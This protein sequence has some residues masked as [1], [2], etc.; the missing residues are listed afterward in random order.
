MAEINGFGLGAGR[1]SLDP[2]TVRTMRQICV[3]HGFE[4]CKSGRQIYPSSSF[5]KAEHISIL[6][7]EAPLRPYTR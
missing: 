6:I 7:V 4:E 2:V 1:P 3:V 5:M